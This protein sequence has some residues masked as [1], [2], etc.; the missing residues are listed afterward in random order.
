MG[1]ALIQ[2]CLGITASVCLLVSVSQIRE[3]LLSSSERPWLCQ[4]LWAGADQGL[5]P[6]EI[7]FPAPLW[8]QVNTG[9][10][11]RLPPLPTNN[12]IP[13]ATAAAAAHSDCVW[14]QCPQALLP[15]P[16]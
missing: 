4:R 7:K 16:S 6:T 11:A 10:T 3:Y 13:E 15:S 14:L 5:V 1:A 9:E 8:S 2:L 12:Q